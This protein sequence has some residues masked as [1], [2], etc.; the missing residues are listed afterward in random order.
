MKC[1]KCGE[2]LK[3][4]LGGYISMLQQYQVVTGYS[5]ANGHWVKP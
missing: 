4:I 5:C 3:P 2:E 1:E